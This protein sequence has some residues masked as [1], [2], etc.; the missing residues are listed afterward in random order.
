MPTK[1]ELLRRADLYAQRHGLVRGEQL[2]FG[3]H[4]IVF[5]VESQTKPGRSAIKI[6]EREEPYQRERNVYLRLLRQPV[7][8]SLG[9]RPLKRIRPLFQPGCLFEKL[10]KSHEIPSL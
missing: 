1:Q 10:R 7:R 6:H 5:V 9:K 3:V 2:G 8:L 4:G